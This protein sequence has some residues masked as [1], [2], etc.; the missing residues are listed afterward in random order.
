MAF[1]AYK[2]GC[3]GTITAATV[4]ANNNMPEVLAIIEMWKSSNTVA[5]R[6]VIY[7][8]SVWQPIGLYKTII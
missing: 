7:C 8:C 4:I 3:Q 2:L 6:C 5:V 1:S